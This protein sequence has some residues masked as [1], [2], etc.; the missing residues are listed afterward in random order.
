MVSESTGCY[1]Y[2]KNLMT[3]EVDN[4]GHYS[5]WLPLMV[6]TLKDSPLFI[7]YNSSSSSTLS[8]FLKVNDFS[9]PVKFS[10]FWLW[11]MQFFIWD[12]FILFLKV[13]ATDDNWLQKKIQAVNSNP[14]VYQIVR[15]PF[16]Q[17]KTSYNND[18]TM[19][20]SVFE[21]TWTWI[22]WLDFDLKK[23]TFP[24]SHQLIP[25]PL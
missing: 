24:V 18:D 16:R 17:L 3:F 11:S 13:S 12:G 10:I 15:F 7:E 14:A 5:K 23:L 1:R 4:K 6:I 9:R 22:R 25:E 8:Y 2:L 19:F 20:W 21:V